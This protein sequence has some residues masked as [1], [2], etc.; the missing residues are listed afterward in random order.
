MSRI[1]HPVESAPKIGGSWIER[2]ATPAIAYTIG[3]VLTA[4]AV[5]VTASDS[6]STDPWLAAVA[7]GTIV[8]VP[9]GVGVYARAWRPY[10]RF[11]LMLVLIGAGWSLAALAESSDGVLY[12]TGRVAAWIVE[13]GFV[14]V[15]LAFPSG[16]L[17]VRRDR[18]L[19]TAFAV[20]VLVGYMPSALLADHYPTPSPWTEC[21]ADCPANAFQVVDSE[22]A[23][24][25]HG[26]PAVREALTM[27]IFLGVAGILA[28]RVRSS[29][30]LTRLM[31][32][33]VLAVAVAR[34]LVYVVGI[35]VRRADPDSPLLGAI[36]WS[37]AL[38]VP[39]MAVAFLIGLLRWQVF[40]AGALQRLAVELHEHPGAQRL[41]NALAAALGDP[42]L[43]LAFW[44]GGSGGG[45]V[46]ADGQ[47]V[48]LTAMS[49]HRSVTTIREGD[50]PIAAMVHDSALDEHPDFVD[51][52]GNYAAMALDNH[53]LVAQVKSSLREVQDSRA[54]I[55]ASADAERRRI[56]RDLHDGA[57][58]RLVALRIKLELA[59]ELLSEDLGR[60][61]ELLHEIGDETVEALENVRSLA[62][63]VYPAVLT[64]RGLRD[65]LRDA[66]V[67]SPIPVRVDVG[68]IGRYPPEIESAVYF[69]CMEAMQNA[70]KHAAG[71]SLIAI[72]LSDDG[73]LRFEVSDNGA[74]FDAAAA[75]PG[76]GLA[77]MRD[78]LEAVGGALTFRSQIGKGT[79]VVGVVPNGG[80][81]L[82][83]A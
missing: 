43:D 37:I 73:R 35:A 30:R 83:G 60:G 39:A 41:R 54:R 24:V 29:T 74:G 31:L 4:L 13:V 46:D 80:V 25:G 19:V 77:N 69:C 8:A 66:A 65:A 51:A 3:F 78:R 32:A 64:D 53:Q 44:R 36:A 63:G 38:L 59:D 1:N 56:E 21:D 16:S 27:L 48:D 42:W 49:R 22:P 82:N 76:A 71:A 67:R 12:S 52:A 20:L 75:P 23:F 14:W 5:V 58:Q 61:R 33:P 2:R 18:V 15:I 7:R 55:V 72:A 11:G 57:Q 50:A 45:W 47:R 40:S 6:S 62:H 28:I 17:T 79:R 26:L 34:L 81:A 68:G 10:R 70:V 9:I